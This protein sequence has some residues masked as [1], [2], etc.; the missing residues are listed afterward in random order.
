M[1]EQKK[2]L[3]KAVAL[4]YNPE[5]DHA[6]RVVATGKGEIADQIVSIAKQYGIAIHKNKDLVDQMLKL[7]LDQE[8]PVEFYSLVAEIF[9]FLLKI[10]NNLEMNKQ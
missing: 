3:N 6:P 9:C 7:Q 2:N 1:A 10:E 8:I 4:A 5:T